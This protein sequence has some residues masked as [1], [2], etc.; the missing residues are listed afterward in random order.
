MGKGTGSMGKEVR[1]WNLPGIFRLGAVGQGQSSG[2]GSGSEPVN[3][4]SQW[5]MGPPVGKG[6]LGGE[7]RAT[8]VPEHIYHSQ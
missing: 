4:H 1:A 3:V 6:D 7:P 2:E 8:V 5:G